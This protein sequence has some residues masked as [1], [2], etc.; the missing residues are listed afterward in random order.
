MMHQ[1]GTEKKV[2]HKS[3]SDA[4]RHIKLSNKTVPSMEI[5][6]EN[7]FFQVKFQFQFS[8]LLSTKKK[9]QQKIFHRLID[10]DDD[11]ND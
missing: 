9:Q 5:V 10:D 4:G 1:Q 2:H 6:M 8:F 3:C 11:G 7:C